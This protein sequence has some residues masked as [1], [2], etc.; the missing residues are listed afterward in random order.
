MSSYSILCAKHELIIR[1]PIG[2][3]A[4]KKK[5]AEFRKVSKL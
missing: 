4:A 1:I 3:R 2:P 5:L